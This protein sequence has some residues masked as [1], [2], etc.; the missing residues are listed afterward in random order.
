[1]DEMFSKIKSLFSSKNAQNDVNR[2]ISEKLHNM[3]FK[4]IQE[5]DETGTE[6]IIARAGHINI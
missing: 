4:Y 6:I 5:K 3:P 1:M 2:R